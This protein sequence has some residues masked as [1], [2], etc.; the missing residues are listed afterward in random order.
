MVEDILEM[1]SIS[2]EEKDR[3]ILELVQNYTE[4]Q[5]NFRSLAERTIKQIDKDTENYARR[6]LRQVYS[7]DIVEEL[8]KYARDKE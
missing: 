2:E 7:D 6:L 3:S 5:K 8:I 1:D 4:D